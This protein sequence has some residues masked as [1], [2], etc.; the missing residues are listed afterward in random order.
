MSDVWTKWAELFWSDVLVLRKIMVGTKFGWT[1]NEKNVHPLVHWTIFLFD[2]V[3]LVKDEHSL[4][5]L[6]WK[7][8][9]N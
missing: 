2:T 5:D 7:I 4:P 8:Q 3:I 1:K 9:M 6:G